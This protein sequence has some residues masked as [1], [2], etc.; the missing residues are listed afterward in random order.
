M[1]LVRTL[2]VDG[3]DMQWR[4]FMEIPYLVGTDAVEAGEIRT[5]EQVIDGG[6]GLFYAVGTNSYYIHL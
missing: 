5:F 1:D 3:M 6:A 4:A 2:F